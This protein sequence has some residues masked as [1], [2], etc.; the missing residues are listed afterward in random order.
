MTLLLIALASIAIT[1]VITLLVLNLTLGK[2]RISVPLDGLHPVS[3]A[4]FTRTMSM[5]MPRPMLPGNRIRALCNGDEIFPAM[6]DAIRGAATSVT[7]E[8]YIYW[9]GTS[10]DAFSKAIAD[11]ASRGCAVKLMLDW[12]GGDLHRGQLRTMREAGVDIRRYNPPHW[13]HLGV[14]NN[15]THRKLMVVDGRIGFIGGVGLAD[16]WSGHAQDPQHWR[17]T[18]FRVEG[19]VVSQLQSAFVDNWLQTAGEL[20]YGAT[21]FADD[22]AS[23]GPSCAQVFTSS[24][25]GGSRSMR[26][27]YLLSIDAAFESLD[28]SASYFVPDTM[29]IAA[30]VRAARRGVRV[31]ILVPGRHID[32]SLV[33]HASRSRWGPM[34]EAG[35]ELYEYG[36]TM[37]HCKVLVADRTWVT[38]GSTNFDARSFD[39][40]DEANLNVHDAAFAEALTRI[41]EDDLRHAARITLTAWRDRSW[42]QRIADRSAAL[43]AAQL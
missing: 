24:P 19:P 6:L 12:V 22:R 16:Q 35:V 3:D 34:L 21:W 39:I 33:R 15:R 18:H 8:T 37:F 4:R 43:L 9:S 26:L 1:F 40:N 14:F 42:S 10:G 7:L 20:L 23:I 29:S 11:A 17:D 30:L 31:R 32:K 38:V 5:V 36:P 27:L 41:F 2:R 13:M 28:L 25:Q